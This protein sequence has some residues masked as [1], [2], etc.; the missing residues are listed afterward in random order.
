MEKTKTIPRRDDQRGMDFT[1]FSNRI[2]KVIRGEKKFI[3]VGMLFL[4]AG[5][6]PFIASMWSVELEL[7]KAAGAPQVAQKFTLLEAQELKDWLDQ[8][9]PLLLMDVRSPAEFA[10]GHI[11]NAVN[12]H[13]VR[14]SSTAS[15]HEEQDLPMVIYCAGPSE[16]AHS[17]CARAI[18]KALQSSSQQFYWFKGGMTAWLAQG[19]PVRRSSS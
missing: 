4:L 17:P 12:K 10:A 13:A 16:S 2:Q 8:G 3:A 18:V 14:P 15:E 1:D 19:Y 7:P 6:L 11:P 5:W 9:V